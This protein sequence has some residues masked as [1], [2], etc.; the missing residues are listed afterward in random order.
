MSTKI[1]LLLIICSV[2]VAA[3]AVGSN[4]GFKLNYALATNTDGNNIN[5]VA[6]PYFNNYLSAAAMCT[7]INTVDCTAGLATSIAYFN[8]ATNTYASFICGGTKG[9]FNIQAAKGYAVSVS[10]NTCTWKLVGSHNDSY[11]TAP[12]GVSFATNTD[13]NNINWVSVPY[14]STSALASALCTEIKTACSNIATSAAYFNTATNTY[15]SFICGGTKGDFNILPGRAI[16]VS[17]S[18]AGSSCWHPAHY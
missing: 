18:A 6:I 11:D 17:V 8:T 4:M 13:G 15:A 3:V 12:T 10:A 16:A 2:F 5:W 7:D 14:H 1:K 9:D